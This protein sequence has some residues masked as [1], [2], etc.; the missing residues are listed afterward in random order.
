MADEPRGVRGPSDPKGPFHLAGIPDVRFSERQK[1]ALEELAN[2]D[3]W[4]KARNAYD[5]SNRPIIRRQCNPL[6]IPAEQQDW[7]EFWTIHVPRTVVAWDP[8]Q[9]VY[10]RT[11]RIDLDRVTDDD[12]RR[13]TYRTPPSERLGELHAKNSNQELRQAIADRRLMVYPSADEAERAAQT[14]WREYWGPRIDKANSET[15]Q[16]F[17]SNAVIKA[18]R[19][20]VFTVNLQD[21]AH[22]L[23]YDLW[24]EDYP[25]G[26]PPGVTVHYK[27][28]DT[29]NLIPDRVELPQGMASPWALRPV[30]DATWVMSAYSVQAGWQV[31][32]D[33]QQRPVILQASTAAEARTWLPPAW[34]AA[35]EGVS[36][37]D[38]ALLDLRAEWGQ[39]V[40]VVSDAT[41]CPAF[42]VPTGFGSPV[43]FRTAESTNSLDAERPNTPVVDDDFLDA[44]DPTDRRASWNPLEREQTAIDP[45]PWT[46]VS[47]HSKNSRWALAR[48]DE[49]GFPEF[50]SNGTG[51]IV[52]FEGKTADQ[53]RHLIPKDVPLTDDTLVDL[54]RASQR[55]LRDLQH[56]A[57]QVTASDPTDQGLHAA[58]ASWA[59]PGNAPEAFVRLAMASQGKTPPEILENL[60]RDENWG[61]VYTVARNSHST[62]G[63]LE[64]LT[65]RLDHSVDESASSFDRELQSAVRLAIAQHPQVTDAILQHLVVNQPDSSVDRSVQRQLTPDQWQAWT[66]HDDPA[67]RSWVAMADRAPAEPLT[68]LAA[69]ADWRVVSRLTHNLSTP[70]AALEHM[71]QR[72][73]ASDGPMPALAK[74]SAPE[75]TVGGL[76]ANQW[77]EFRQGIIAH[78][79][80]TPE[81][82][83][84][85]QADP[86]GTI[87]RFAEE[88]TTWV[89]T[90]E[91]DIASG[92]TAKVPE[93]PSSSDL[94]DPQRMNQWFILARAHATH[95]YRH[96]EVETWLSAEQ[97]LG[98]TLKALK[99]ETPEGQATHW[100]AVRNAIVNVHHVVFPPTGTLTEDSQALDQAH[101][102][103]ERT[104]HEAFAPASDPALLTRENAWLRPGGPLSRIEAAYRAKMEEPEAKASPNPA[105]PPTPEAALLARAQYW[106]IQSGALTRDSLG[107]FQ[108]GRIAELGFADTRVESK[109][110]IDGLGDWVAYPTPRGHYLVGQMHKNGQLGHVDL[111]VYRD[112]EAVRAR[113]AN[114]GGNLTIEAN[115]QLFETWATRLA[116]DA[117]KEA[118]AIIAREADPSHR[119]VRE[120]Q[121]LHQAYTK[122]LDGEDDPKPVIETPQRTPRQL[123]VTPLGGGR[124]MVWQFTDEA[125]RHDATEELVQRK[126][127]DVVA[128][129]KRSK[130][131]RPFPK[132]GQPRPVWEQIPATQKPWVVESDDPHAAITELVALAQEQVPTM[133]VEAK[134]STDSHI[135]RALVERYGLEPQPLTQLQEAIWTVHP[136][137][138]RT[139]MASTQMWAVQEKAEYPGEY[140]AYTVAVPFTVQPESG[141]P[142]VIYETLNPV[143]IKEKLE[144]NGLV[145]QSKDTLP[146]QVADWFKP[147]DPK[148]SLETPPVRWGPI[149]PVTALSRADRPIRNMVLH[150][151]RDAQEDAEIPPTIRL[152][153]RRMLVGLVQKGLHAEDF[154][155]LE[156]PYEKLHRNQ[157]KQQDPAA[158]AQATAT[159]GEVEQQIREYAKEWLAER[160]KLAEKL[161]HP[162][163]TQRLQPRSSLATAGVSI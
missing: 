86:N 73:Y 47:I 132:A 36:P 23:Q 130:G 105:M 72:L 71:A 17:E 121:G 137:P 31:V 136:T 80:T 75:E 156:V 64:Y 111:P 29:Q 81:V 48:L 104:I 50:W 162:A 74:L 147:K 5:D 83:R 38:S 87:R 69:D 131:W 45:N 56:Q 82:L 20:E 97:A 70:P 77:L 7:P 30:G 152:M 2:E 33:D 66:H 154:A 63:T 62:L 115:P 49:Q 125:H 52:A 129:N 18:I 26:F 89:T 140:D 114:Q 91:P 100:D 101:D 12:L 84:V 95:P 16:N 126:G 127:T 79:L 143:T 112:W 85:A 145:V 14:V 68:A 159:W 150:D 106:R 15:R 157:P 133:S 155:S 11:R 57:A 113:V 94:S 93:R 120:R 21:P 163:P 117:P 53:V 4:Y 116:K 58:Q 96:P 110:H 107:I 6:L 25:E 158:L 19:E 122:A 61:V 103:L 51:Q 28:A 144:R 37:T 39:E 67:V 32:H 109:A 134:L 46:I 135:I 151:L 102:R 146:P 142:R 1:E 148:L 119:A 124:G 98:T 123:F 59:Q 88:R 160:P 35:F 139:A 149:D 3:Q 65:D 90:P 60:A 44:L 27:H 13:Y 99:A 34:Q 10:D 138:K 78:P 8:R 108:K 128:L 9:I 141:A 40:T 55:S 43:D 22:R 41:A 118:E 76:T 24:V 153:Q 161:T 42:V 92:E 54:S